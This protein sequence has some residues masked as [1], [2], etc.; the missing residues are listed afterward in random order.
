MDIQATTP[1]SHLNVKEM[2]DLTNQPFFK[3]SIGERASELGD[4]TYIGYKY[5]YHWNGNKRLTLFVNLYFYMKGAK[6]SKRVKNSKD[7][8]RTGPRPMYTLVAKFP[9]TTKVKNMKRLYDIPMQIFSSDPS[10]KF[11]FAYALHRLKAVVVDDPQITKWL[12]KSLTT[13]PT[14]TNPD[15]QVQ[16]TKHFY[17]FF[18]FLGNH[19]PKEYLNDKFLIDQNKN[20]KIINQKI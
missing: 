16:L 15:L 7:G 12:G 4:I 6:G 19:K 2:I 14:K 3:R 11:Y 9:Y 10:F 17:K 8:R 18:K 20:V 5:S 13:A 1:Q